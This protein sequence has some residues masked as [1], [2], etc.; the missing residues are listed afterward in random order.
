MN[1]SNL[2]SKVFLPVS[3]LI[4]V[5]LF[6]VLVFSQPQPSVFA[7]SQASSVSQ[8]D[9]L[10]R[11][12]GQ[13]PGV[14]PLSGSPGSTITVSGSG[15][16]SFTNVESIE[17]GGIEILSD[18]TAVTDT[19]GAFQVSGLIV[20]QL[21]AGTVVLSVTVGTG[22]QEVTAV[23]TFLVTEPDETSQSAVLT[24]E[25]ALAPLSGFLERVF[26]FDNRSKTWNFYDPRPL[27]ADVNDIAEFTQ[28]QV[29]WI[30][31]TSS[32]TVTLNGQQRVL[33]CSNEGT[34]QQDCWNLIVW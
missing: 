8:L 23:G 14:S 3:V 24:P 28:G 9:Q 30:K 32:I 1:F 27:F 12:S 19:N 16:Q 11:P 22:Q 2:C 34:P 29:Y 21:N 4:L 31:V 26:H 18:P 33:T 10:L 5:S 20:P 25:E 15:F 7:D 6:A 13:T 17:L